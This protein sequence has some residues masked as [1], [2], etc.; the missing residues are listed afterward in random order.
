MNPTSWLLTRRLSVGESAR[1]KR[2]S[3]HS[4]FYKMVQCFYLWWWKC[5]HIKKAAWDKQ[6]TSRRF[7]SSGLVCTSLEVRARTLALMSML[8]LHRDAAFMY[9]SS[10]YPLCCY[11]TQEWTQST[12]PKHE[13]SERNVKTQKRCFFFNRR[14]KNVC[15]AHW[16][17]TLA[18]ALDG[19]KG[20]K[21]NRTYRVEYP[22]RGTQIESVMSAVHHSG[23]M[24]N[25]LLI[26]TDTR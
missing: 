24:L 25:G 5:S 4:W 1:W 23:A 26:L 20:A 7:E 9:Q 19:E 22:F 8:S 12:L 14:K 15:R 10:L 11:A 3:R 16:S 17:L 13:T 2:V 18:S 6:E 21:P